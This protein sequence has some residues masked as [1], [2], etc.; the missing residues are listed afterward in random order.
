MLTK[1]WVLIRIFT[2]K[3][4]PDLVISVR[5]TLPVYI[6]VPLRS[7]P[8]PPSLP[9]PLPTF[10]NEKQAVLRHRNYLLR[11]RF[12]LLKSYGSGSDS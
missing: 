9:P 12:R 8:P 10:L 3:P 4:D 1:T 2:Q 5:N 6:M 11:F 7:H